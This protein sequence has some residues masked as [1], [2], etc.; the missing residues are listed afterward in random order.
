MRT[1]RPLPAAQQLALCV[2][3][4]GALTL[5][6]MEQDTA[7]A[8]LGLAPAEAET[9]ARGTA[10]PGVPVIVAPVRLARD[11]IELDV[12]GTGRAQRS[13][14]LRN[15]ASGKV[16]EMALA[17][18]RRFAEGDVLLRLEDADERL[19]LSLAETR[20]AEANRVAERFDRLQ[21]RAVAST[22]R[23]DE[24]RTAAEVARLEVAR[25]REALADRTL[26]AP[27]DGVSGLP[28][29]E[30]GDWID[31]DVEIAS[32]D[33]RSVILVEFDLPEAVLA[34]VREGLA[35]EARTPAFADRVFEGEVAALDS[36]VDPASRTAR[37]RVA[38]RNDEDL[39]RPGA[40]FTI[41]LRLPGGAY[42]TVPELAIQ[43]ARGGLHVWRV[44]ADA[45]ERVP[46]RMIRRR[47]GD[48]LVD[49]DLALG[50]AVVVEGTQ[51][52]SPG[53]AVT[54]QGGAPEP[55]T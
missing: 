22:A 7:R 40:S 5:L 47:A 24:V 35:V 21:D 29:I 52:L 45:A 46:V 14:T 32:F 10:R 20:L 31:S 23:L 11:D 49:G 12:V 16:V 33:D 27:F 13:V 18:N 43:F 9:P 39:L 8:L 44:S 37:V 42:P 17:P 3:L 50:D 51:R 1:R 2:A 19:A 4:G 25:A 48:V 6:W 30:P 54:I 55:A 28:D 53:R 15:E 34:R 41:A 26:R 38:I 36:R